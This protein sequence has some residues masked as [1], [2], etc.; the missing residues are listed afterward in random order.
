MKRSFLISGILHLGVLLYLINDTSKKN[1]SADA[2]LEVV[3]IPKIPNAEPQK[4][5]VPRQQKIPR[6]RIEDFFSLTSE[7]VAQ[8]NRQSSDSSHLTTVTTTHGDGNISIELL[9][10]PEDTPLLNVLA[11]LLHEKLKYPSDLFRLSPAGKVWGDIILS[12]QNDLALHEI[13]LAAQEKY[14]GVHVIRE[15]SEIGDA[16]NAIIKKKM[17]SDSPRTI[18]VKIFFKSGSLTN[19][20]TIKLTEERCVNSG[21]A[22]RGS[23]IM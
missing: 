12:R 20:F 13:K 5:S 11:R 22:P 15:L 18:H 16:H 2:I 21:S 17:T 9:G 4:I 1:T 3:L 10:K 14:L 7:K 8:E 19:G 6:L 23:K